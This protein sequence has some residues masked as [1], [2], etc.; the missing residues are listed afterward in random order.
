MRNTNLLQT[1]MSVLHAHTAHHELVVGYHACQ[2]TL[3][4]ALRFSFGLLVRIKFYYR[5]LTHRMKLSPAMI[6]LMCRLQP[7]ATLPPLA[8]ALVLGFP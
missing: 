1:T 4:S 3:A 2:Q 5:T 8:V 6:G 7:L